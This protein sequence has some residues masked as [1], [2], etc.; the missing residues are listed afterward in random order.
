MENNSLKNL[1]CCLALAV[2]M[3]LELILQFWETSPV[4]FI[5]DEELI[6]VFS[7]LCMHPDLLSR[8]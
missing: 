1:P 5:N 7:V 3:L 2:A 4:F 6:V 8:N